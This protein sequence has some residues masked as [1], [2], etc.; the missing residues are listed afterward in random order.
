ML[1]I[2]RCLL[3]CILQLVSTLVFQIAAQG[4]PPS[5]L[6]SEFHVIG[7]RTKENKTVYFLRTL[8]GIECTNNPLNRL[9]LLSEDQW[10]YPNPESGCGPVAMLNLLVW[11]E[12]Y[13]LINPLYRDANPTKYKFKLFQEIDRRLTKQAGAVRTQE[14]GVKNLDIAIVMDSIVSECSKGAVRIHTDA[15]S[16]PLKLNDFL[17]SMQNFRSGYLIVRPE[18][19]QTGKLSNDHATVIIRADRA[20]NITLATWGQY[21]HGLLKMKNGEQWF[22]PQDPSHMKLKIIALIRF[23]PFKPAT[24]KF[25]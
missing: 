23:I 9:S 18:N 24:M 16:A 3:I 13:G 4:H 19:P 22:I 1:I 5:E 25:D 21:Y 7:Q 14:H 6:K 2:K 11:Y 17:E 12:K 10:N 20:G 15:I 8:N